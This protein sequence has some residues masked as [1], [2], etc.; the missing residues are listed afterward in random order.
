MSVKQW[1]NKLVISTG[2]SHGGT[3]LNQCIFSL[4]VS[5]FVHDFCNICICCPF[6]C[7][8]SNLQSNCLAAG[9][10]LFFKG[11]LEAKLI[12]AEISFCLKHSISFYLL[13]FVLIIA[14]LTQGRNMA[15]R[16]GILSPINL[17]NPSSDF[18]YI[19]KYASRKAAYKLSAFIPVWLTSLTFIW[20]GKLFSQLDTSSL[21][22]GI[23]EAEATCTCRFFGSGPIGNFLGLSWIWH[24]SW[25]GNSVLALLSSQHS[26]T[27]Y[28]FAMG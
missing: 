14:W 2:N 18:I 3:G 9:S 12:S 8:P 13:C 7:W 24:F 5:N 25:I 28:K 1:A 23:E 16:K 15:Y 11:S 26:Y 17:L 22:R 4:Y 21:L 27:Y 10:I 20:K 6:Q 19:V